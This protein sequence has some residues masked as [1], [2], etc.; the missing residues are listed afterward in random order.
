MKQVYKDRKYKITNYN[1]NWIKQFEAEATVIKSIFGTDAKKLEHIGSTSV[2]GMLGK[3]TIDVLILVEDAQV[4]DKYIQQMEMA[5]YTAKGEMVKPGSRLFVKQADNAVLANVHVFPEGHPHVKI[6]L[7]LRDYLRS[8]PETVKEY[9]ALKEQLY[10]KYQDDYSQYR[11][12]KD[13]YMEE[14][15][16]R[17]GLVV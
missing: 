5:G 13:V 4:A 17:I 14:L 7:G 9:S 10:I 16:K 3:P 8:H 2:P 11:K 1:D 6:M 12:Q 15:K